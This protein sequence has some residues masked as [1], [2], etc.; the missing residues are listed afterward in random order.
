M[1]A[2][3][4]KAPSAVDHP[5]AHELRKANGNIRSRSAWRLPTLPAP[6][7]C[8]APLAVV[9]DNLAK[10]GI[11]RIDYQWGFDAEALMTVTRVVAPRPWKTGLALFDQPTFEKSSLLPMPESVTS[12]VELSVNPGKLLDELE[13]LGP[14]GVVKAQI[15][16]LSEKIKSAGQIDLKKDI[17]GHLGPRVVAYLGPDRSAAANDDSLESA[18]RNGLTSTAA[19]TAMQS[20]LPKLTLVAE[21][22]DPVAFGKGLDTMIIAINNE[23]EAQALEKEQEERK[24]EEKAKAAGRAAPT[25]KKGGGRAAEASVRRKAAFWRRGSIRYLARASR[26]CSMTPSDSKLRF[27]PSSFR[28]TI[29]VQGKFVAFAVSTDAARAAVAAVASKDWKPSS[30][31]ER[32][33][34]HVP[35]KLVM[36]SVTD[37]SEP[38][39]S[40]L[41]SL[42][43]TLQTMINTSIALAKSRA[44]GAVAGGG[45]GPGPGMGPGGMPPGMGRSAPGGMP[46]GG[47]KRMT[48]MGGSPGGPGGGAAPGGPGFGSGQR[49]NPGAPSSGAAESDSMIILKV[50]S[51]KLPRASDLKALL[52]PATLSVQAAEQEV[53]FISR[54]AFPDL[55]AVIGMVPAM[56]MMPKPPFLNQ[57]PGVQP[58]ATAEGAAGQAGATPAAPAAPPDGPAARGP[59][60]RRG[61]GE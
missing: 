2:L 55:T 36:L 14:P 10:S 15:D 50:D 60:G 22:D 17:L 25:A 3:D 18:L 54:S 44:A 6:L 56:G 46:G 45:N 5:I 41:A 51:D 31:I 7:P 12:F 8:P 38:L 61:R 30:E 11:N 19:I 13:Q 59:R 52:F 40:L 28:P 43:G 47:M 37:T 34:A 39:S 26:L 33:C 35:S 58:G 48:P 24:A 53:R 49:G 27:G 9:H 4:G 57:I 16:E 23:L 29:L 21:I 32:V 42:P 1:A 20:Y